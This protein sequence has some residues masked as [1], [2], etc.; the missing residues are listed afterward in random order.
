MLTYTRG[1]LVITYTLTSG[2]EGG[3]RRRGVGLFKVESDSERIRDKNLGGRVVYEGNSVVVSPIC[4][5]TGRR[6]PDFPGYRLNIGVFDPFGP[7]I[8]TFEVQS[9]SG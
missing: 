9:E 8:Q 3:V 1:A 5:L 6:R 7:N 2:E 4:F